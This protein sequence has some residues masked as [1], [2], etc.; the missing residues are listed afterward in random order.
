MEQEVNAFEAYQKDCLD[1]ASL[2][3]KN[4]GAGVSSTPP[5]PADAMEQLEAGKRRINDLRDR[6]QH[7][8]ELL[9]DTPQEK[10]KEQ[11]YQE[12]RKQQEVARQQVNELM[13][14]HPRTRS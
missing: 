14:I 11:Q 7:K 10:A 5:P 12:Q 13:N 2:F 3:A 8:D 6:L 9:A 1:Q 4:S